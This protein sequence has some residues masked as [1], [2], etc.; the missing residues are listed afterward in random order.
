MKLIGIDQVSITVED[1]WSGNR[2]MWWD[3]DVYRKP[4]VIIGAIHRTLKPGAV[5]YRLR[6]FKV[7]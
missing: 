3:T 2:E 7:R 1:V 6:L 5:H 4:A